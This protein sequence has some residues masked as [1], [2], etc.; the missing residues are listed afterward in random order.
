MNILRNTL[1]LI[2]TV[3]LYL[4]IDYFFGRNILNFLKTQSDGIVLFS[5][6]DKKLGLTFQENLEVKNAQWGNIYYTFCTN[7]LSL[8]SECNKQITKNNYKF[9]FIGDSFTEGIGVNYEN[10]FVGLFDQV[11]D[12]TLNLSVSGSSPNFYEKRLNYFLN[13]K[14]IKIENLFLFFDLTDLEDDFGYETKGINYIDNYEIDLSKEKYKKF[15]KDNFVIT[16]HILL[17]TWWNHIRGFFVSDILNLR[18]SDKRY[19][20]DYL[21]TFDLNIFERKRDIVI[22]NLNKIVKLTKSKNINFY[23]VIY[24]HPGTIVHLKDEKNSRNKKLISTFCKQNENCEFINLYPAFFKQVNETSKKA[25]I[26]KFYF[27]GDSHFNQNGHRFIF[28]ELIKNYY[29]KL[30]KLN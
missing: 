13:E 14:N 12:K 23:I 27:K 5:F 15:L 18:Y 26:R 22:N 25:V 21:D 8:K 28:E 24:P 3:L 16:Y 2:I 19:S 7:D 20:W 6:K 11:F 4:F 29:Y 30:N 1:I 17:N 9:A 10:T